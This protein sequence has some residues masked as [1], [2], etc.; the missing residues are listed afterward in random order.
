MN[1]TVFKKP[2]KKWRPVNK[3]AALITRR[4]NPLLLHVAPAVSVKA[5]TLAER[6]EAESKIRLARIARLEVEAKERIARRAANRMA[7][8][9]APTVKPYRHLWA[10]RYLK[11]MNKSRGLPAPT[12][13]EL[14]DFIK[15]QPNFGKPIT[16]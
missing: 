14:L 10:T 11:R 12:N 5:P 4:A 9:K 15:S 13:Q 16:P 3:Q 1:E 8:Q 2:E 6:L 7:N